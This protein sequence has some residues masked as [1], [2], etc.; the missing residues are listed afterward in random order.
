M[1]F[2][3][4]SQRGWLPL[5][6]A[7]L[8]LLAACGGPSATTSTGGPGAPTA[9]TASSSTVSASTS[10][11]DLLSLGDVSAVVGGTDSSIAR[12]KTTAA[13][14]STSVNCTYLPGAGGAHVGAE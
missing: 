3:T 10:L 7:A 9:T 12:N 6:A 14:G 4:R 5:A 2:M 8:L 11:C 13:D 1:R